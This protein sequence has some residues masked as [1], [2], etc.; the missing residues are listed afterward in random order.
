MSLEPTRTQIMPPLPTQPVQRLVA[1]VEATPSRWM[2]AF[3]GMPGSGKTTLASRL[4][5]AINA[6]TAP[7]T[8][9]ALGMDGFH[10]TE[11]LI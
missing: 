8:V 7:N 3:A 6:R 10:F 11:P 1:Q 5:Q 9:V 2:I 4:A